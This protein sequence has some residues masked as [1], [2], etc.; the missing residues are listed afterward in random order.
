[1]CWETKPSA[2]IWRKM[3]SDYILKW[4]YNLKFRIWEWCTCIC[5]WVR[6]VGHV[7]G[8]SARLRLE[9]PNV[10]VCNVR[11][12]C[13][14][15]VCIYMHVCEPYIYRDSAYVCCVHT[16]R[17]MFDNVHSA[18]ICRCAQCSNFKLWTRIYIYPKTARTCLNNDNS[19]GRE[20]GSSSLYNLN[21]AHEIIH[22]RMT[23]GT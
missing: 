7:Y 9:F 18:I 8:Y 1:M 3:H 17:C 6:V 13:T 22:V 20:R 2:S 12:V 15:C 23:R 21:T 10:C 5:I 16:S 4:R 14:I 11:I 19:L